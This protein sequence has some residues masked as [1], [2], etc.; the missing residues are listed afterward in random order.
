MLS[1]LRI[2]VDLSKPEMN[3]FMKARFVAQ[4]IPTLALINHNDNSLKRF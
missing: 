2:T 4:I 1:N 3:T